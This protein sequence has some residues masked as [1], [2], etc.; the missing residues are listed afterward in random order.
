VKKAT[1]LLLLLLCGCS[2]A[3]VADLLDWLRPSHV[4]IGKTAPYGGVCVPQGGPIAPTPVPVI[5]GPPGPGLPPP[6]PGGVPVG[7]P[8]G[9]PAPPVPVGVAPPPFPPGG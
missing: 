5:A 8:A 6:P 9:V 2:T 1:A 3:P 7:P 4:E